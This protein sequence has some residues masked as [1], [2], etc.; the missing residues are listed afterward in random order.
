MCVP[1]HFLFE[2]TVMPSL[3]LTLGFHSL[4]AEVSLSLDQSSKKYHFLVLSSLLENKGT[5][6]L[7]IGLSVSKDRGKIHSLPFRGVKLQ[8]KAYTL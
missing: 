5:K 4:Q 6:V 7:S 8:R 1:F 3:F 2:D